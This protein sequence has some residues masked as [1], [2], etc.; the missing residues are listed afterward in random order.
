MRI[1]LPSGTEAEIERVAGAT[2]GLVVIP[3]IWGMRPLFDDLVRRFASEWGTTTVAIEP[4]PA[5]DFPDLGTNPDTRFAAVPNLRDT[6]KYRDLAE[7]AEATGC[8]SV[9]LIGFCMGGMYCFKAAQLAR[10]GRLLFDRIV[11]FYGMITTPDAW[12]SATHES[13]LDI[14]KRGATGTTRAYASNV[15]AVIGGADQWTPTPEVEELRATGVTV[16]FYPQ[17]DH[18]FAHDASR[19]THRPEDARDAFERA[20]NWLA[21]G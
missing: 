19:P 1:T 6:D 9:G 21:G 20:K 7:A 16:A 12:K 2:R 4:F 11:S 5:R 14:L 15:L 17:A 8:S 13:P 18:G 10:D 3:D